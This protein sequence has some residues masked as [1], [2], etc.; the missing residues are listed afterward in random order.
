M[1]NNHSMTDLYLSDKKLMLKYFANRRITFLIQFFFLFLKVLYWF[2]LRQ[3]NLSTGEEYNFHRWDFTS[4]WYLI[5]PT[6]IIYMFILF[7]LS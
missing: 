3:K 5:I 7:N 4:M 1:K 6:C 2:Y